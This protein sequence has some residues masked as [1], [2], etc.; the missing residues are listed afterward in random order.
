M[1]A[2]TDI[3]YQALEKVNFHPPQPSICYIILPS[4]VVFGSASVFNLTAMTLVRYIFI[5]YPLHFTRY[6]TA[7]R[8]AAIVL[9]VW[10]TA[11]CLAFPPQIWRPEGV[12]CST[13]K[14]SDEHI[15]N[16]AIYMGTEW[17]FWFFIPLM[18]I[19]FS[20]Y[21]IYLMARGQARQIAALEVPQTLKGLLLR[22]EGELP[23]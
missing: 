10:L 9:A 19:S 2:C 7:H 12:V 8:S 17:L 13:T 3:V 20:Y 18:L 6:V 14:P 11:F 21:R 1:L 15:V 23:R 22:S 16:E 4:G 5:R